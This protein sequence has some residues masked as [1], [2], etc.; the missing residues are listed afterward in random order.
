[1]LPHS[2]FYPNTTIHTHFNTSIPESCIQPVR[3]KSMDMLEDLNMKIYV[4]DKKIVLAGKAWEV[5]EQL[6]TYGKHFIYV[7][8]WI[9]SVKS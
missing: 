1:M 7:K 5:K 4:Y 9:H 6:K 3:L 8:D 2:L